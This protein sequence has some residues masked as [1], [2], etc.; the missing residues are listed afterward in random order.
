MGKDTVA[1]RSAGTIAL[2]WV[3]QEFQNGIDGGK[4]ID[5][6]DLVE[7]SDAFAAG[8]LR[9]AREGASKRSVGITM[10]YAAVN[11]F[12]LFDMRAELP[13]LLRCLASE[14]DSGVEVESIDPK[15]RQ[16]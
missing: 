2:P 5:F 6:R 4:A 8:Y 16:M 9:L 7:V 11:V 3:V 13:E 14:I 15:L 10:L 12:D 1:G